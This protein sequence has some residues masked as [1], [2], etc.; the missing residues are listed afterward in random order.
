M[1]ENKYEQRAQ[2]RSQVSERRGSCLG[3]EVPWVQGSTDHW[4]F[5]APL[6]SSCYQ[7]Q[8][9]DLI[10][11]S[12]PTPVYLPHWFSYGAIVNEVDLFLIFLCGILCYSW[13]VNFYLSLSL[14]F[15]F[16]SYPVGILFDTSPGSF[17]HTSCKVLPSSYSVI[18]CI[19]SNS[20]SPFF[21]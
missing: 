6:A 12:V 18:Y 3:A 10:F 5:I 2:Q 19:C 13:A 16:Q 7:C 20:L 8:V 11:N 4:I 21:K 1:R 14:F 17:P 9:P 15:F